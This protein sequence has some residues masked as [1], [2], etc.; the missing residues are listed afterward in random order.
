M[1]KNRIERR[2]RRIAKAV[3]EHVYT[4]RSG[5]WEWEWWPWLKCLCWCFDDD[6]DDDDDDDELWLCKQLLIIF[7]CYD[8]FSGWDQVDGD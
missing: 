3:G 5:W 1:T 2:R 7:I 8:V 4:G 6:D